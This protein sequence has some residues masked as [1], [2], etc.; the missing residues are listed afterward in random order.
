MDALLKQVELWLTNAHLS[1]HLEEALTSII[2]WV[3]ANGFKFQVSSM[4]TQNVQRFR[5]GLLR[6]F[7]VHAWCRT[8]LLVINDLASALVEID[9]E[10][11][12]LLD[13]GHVKDFSQI[14]VYLIA[15]VPKVLVVEFW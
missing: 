2:E 5:L 6:M 8:L 4:A 13:I 7:L 1:I 10:E 9:I 12:H 14:K 15:F 11:D 3:V